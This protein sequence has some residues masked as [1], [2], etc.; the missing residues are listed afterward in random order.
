MSVEKLMGRL[1]GEYSE[2]VLIELYVGADDK[3]SSINILQVSLKLHKCHQWQIQFKSSAVRSASFGIAK[4]RLLFKSKQWRWLKSIPSLHDTNCNSSRSECWK[5]C[6]RVGTCC[7]VRKE[8]SKCKQENLISKTV[9]CQYI[10]LSIFNDRHR[11]RRSIGMI[12]RQFIVNW[13][14]SICSEKC[15]NSIG[16]SICKRHSV[17][18]NWGMMRRLL[19]TQCHISYRW[20]G[21]YM[22]QIVASFTIIW[23]GGW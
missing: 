16:E 15:H 11:F 12:H 6:T 4:S 21:F 20:E 10:Q 3:N 14:L 9:T 18:C 19:F 8:I 23:F 2:P 22:K 5:C 7:N 17:M 1:R 13:P